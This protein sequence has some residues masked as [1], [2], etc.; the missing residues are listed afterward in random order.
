MFP[1]PFV[2][3]LNDLRQDGPVP[4][5]DV[6]T[7]QT[8]TSRCPDVFVVS[9]WM[10]VLPMSIVIPEDGSLDT[11]AAPKGLVCV[12]KR[13]S[14]VISP[15]PNPLVHMDDVPVL[16][17]DVTEQTKVF[18]P[19]DQPLKRVIDNP[20]VAKI[21]QTLLVDMNVTIEEVP[22]VSIRGGSR[23]GGICRRGQQ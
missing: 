7:R 13:L 2:Q 3:F 15:D 4:V 17:L 21:V 20:R 14:M 1:S 19:F 10:F 18:S 8:T 5:A 22:V 11:L 12:V 16:A 9:V 23:V 6:D